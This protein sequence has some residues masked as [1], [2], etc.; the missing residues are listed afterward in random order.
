[1]KRRFRVVLD[2]EVYEVE[3]E[4][5]EGL[6]ELETL[7]RSLQTGVVKSISTAPPRR[8]ARL[9]GAIEAP[10]T[11]RVVEVRVKVGDEVEEGD[12]L[13]VMEAMKTRVEVKAPRGGVV[14]E[15]R[16]KEGDSVRQGDPLLVL[17]K[18]E[19]RASVT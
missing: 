11:G 14:R 3:V 4:V 10:I 6:S 15:V 12:T 5:E 7:I 19:S 9:T 2:G 13:V 16:V 17:S 1:M 8:A 18:A